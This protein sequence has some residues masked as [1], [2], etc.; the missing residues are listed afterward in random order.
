MKCNYVPVL[1]VEGEELAIDEDGRLLHR[2]PEG[3]WVKADDSFEQRLPNLI[4]KE[5]LME[6]FR[7]QSRVLTHQG[8]WRTCCQPHEESQ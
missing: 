6:L 1:L 7:A 3:V 8:F 4:S 5:Q 2:H